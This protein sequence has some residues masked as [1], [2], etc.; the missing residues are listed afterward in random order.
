ML[1]SKYWYS[2]TFAERRR[3]FSD[4][5]SYVNGKVYNYASEVK[6]PQEWS[7]ANYDDWELVHSDTENDIGVVT[8]LQERIDFFNKR[9]DYNDSYLSQHSRDLITL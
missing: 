7:Q 3:L 8:M 6:T 5:N 4:G 9:I 1:L 2:P